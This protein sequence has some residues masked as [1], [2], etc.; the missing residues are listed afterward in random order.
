MDEKEY[1]IIRNSV[2]LTEVNVSELHVT[3]SVYDYK[4]ARRNGENVRQQV[5]FFQ[6]QNETKAI[7][8]YFCSFC[9]C[10][11]EARVS[12]KTEKKL[13]ELFCVTLAVSG[14]LRSKIID[15]NDME[16]FNKTADMLCFPL[17]L[18]YIKSYLQ[19]VSGML[20]VPTFNIPTMDIIKSI[21]K[22]K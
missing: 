15:M 16:K 5:R 8:N 12:I 2:Q 17:L 13:T 4:E 7:E 3:G 9:L 1:K 6:D 10:R 22:N 14:I 18:P 20:A 19:S 11:V 21:E